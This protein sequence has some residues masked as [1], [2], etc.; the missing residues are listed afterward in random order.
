LLRN[1]VNPRSGAE[2]HFIRQNQKYPGASDL[3][4]FVGNGIVDLIWKVVGFML[5]SHSKNKQQ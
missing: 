1:T 4:V 2:T 5:T 3:F